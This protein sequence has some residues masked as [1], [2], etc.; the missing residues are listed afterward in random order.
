M[1][2]PHWQLSVTLPTPSRLMDDFAP[3]WNEYWEASSLSLFDAREFGERV[4][5]F[6]PLVPTPE[7]FVQAG[8]E[9][10]LSSVRGKLQ[11][12]FRRRRSERDFADKSISAKQLSTVF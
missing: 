3:R 10:Q 7:P 9:H 8:E 6:Q 1:V 11:R 12:L 5:A 2:E 4:R